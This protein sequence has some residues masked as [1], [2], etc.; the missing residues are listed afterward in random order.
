MMST[1]PEYVE[2]GLGEVTSIIHY[3]DKQYIPY[4][5]QRLRYIIKDFPYYSLGFHVRVREKAFRALEW[6][7]EHP[8]V[9]YHA[10]DSWN[11]QDNKVYFKKMQL[12]HDSMKTFR[13]YENVDRSDMVKD[14]PFVRDFVSVQ[15]VPFVIKMNFY[16]V[17]DMIYGIEIQDLR[18]DEEAVDYLLRHGRHFLDRK[19]HR[20]DLL[21]VLNWVVH[22][23]DENYKAIAPWYILDNKEY[24]ERMI[25]LRNRIEKYLNSNQKI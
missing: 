11:I 1:I 23:P 17:T 16:L 4:D 13:L 2:E 14:V 7:V 10:L 6:I 21:N 5:K 24:V 3:K 8:E 19:Q 25:L 18:F 22:H 9:D 20:E 15:N 12:L